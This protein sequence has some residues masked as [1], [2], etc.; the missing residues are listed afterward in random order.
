MES[1]FFNPE[2]TR[3]MACFFSSSAF[4]VSALYPFQR[5]PKKANGESPVATS[6]FASSNRH[7][8]KEV[9]RNNTGNLVSICVYSKMSDGCLCHLHS[10]IEE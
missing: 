2:S 1:S 7:V 9:I 6:R 4:Q 10:S 3:T 8:S 5:F